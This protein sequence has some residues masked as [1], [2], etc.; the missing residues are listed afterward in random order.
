MAY[1][2]RVG[3]SKPQVVTSK[4]QG[5]SAKIWHGTLCIASTHAFSSIHYTATRTRANVKKFCP[6]TTPLSKEKTSVCVCC[7]SANTLVLHNLHYPCVGEEMC[8]PLVNT[9]TALDV[10]GV[11]W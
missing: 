8:A 6:P 10:G 2:V 7:A 5:D 9:G 3:T 4:P 1:T 11:G